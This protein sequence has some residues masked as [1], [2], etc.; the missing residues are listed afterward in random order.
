MP[1]SADGL[2][3]KIENHAIKVDNAQDKWDE[4]DNDSKI[5]YF[6]KKFGDEPIVDYIENDNDTME[7]II[8][9]LVADENE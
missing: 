5:E 3:N 6:Q 8:S 4:M 1:D 7:S 9:E 2:F